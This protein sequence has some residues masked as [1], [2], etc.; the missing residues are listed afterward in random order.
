M[1]RLRKKHKEH[2]RVEMARKTQVLEELRIQLITTMKSLPAVS[3]MLVQMRT[4]NTQ[5][6]A[7]HAAMTLDLVINSDAEQPSK[8]DAS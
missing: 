4:E 5:L 6:R 7:R 2:L 3:A 8:C 1:D